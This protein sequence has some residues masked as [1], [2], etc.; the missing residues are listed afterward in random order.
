M[1]FVD[2]REGVLS[3][4]PPVCEASCKER[5][6]EMETFG[7]FTAYGQ[8]TICDQSKLGD[9]EGVSVRSLL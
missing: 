8:E 5:T 1:I 2:D 6:S 9:R 3:V 7:H 4:K